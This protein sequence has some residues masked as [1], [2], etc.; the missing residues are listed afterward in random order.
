M[1]VFV[2]STGRCGSTTF[3][4][5]CRHI[6]NYSSAHESRSG[7]IGAARLEYPGHHIEADNRLSWFL[8]RLETAYGDSATYVHL[9][10]SELETA[11]SLVK[12]YRRRKGIIWA[13][14][15]AILLRSAAGMDPLEVSLDY[16]RTVNSNIEAF[17]RDKTRQMRFSMENADTDFRAFWTLIGAE[18]NL[19]AALA[20]WDQQHN[21][22]PESLNAAPK[23]YSASRAASKVKRIIRTLPDYLKDA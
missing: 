20:E 7:L 4:R 3:S 22:S 17:L 23:K 12:R 8:G 2:L 6:T 1:N 10:R 14:R 15:Q 19:Q 13:Y 11:R 5:A 18:G 16:C 9:V 21:A